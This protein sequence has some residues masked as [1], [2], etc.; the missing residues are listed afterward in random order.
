MFPADQYQGG[1]DD[2]VKIQI[3]EGLRKLDCEPCS[4][5]KFCGYRSYSLVERHRPLLTAV[6]HIEWLARA[7]AF[8]KLGYGLAAWELRHLV[9]FQLAE[10]LATQRRELGQGEEKPVG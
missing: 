8:V 9:T 4:L 7:S 1:M 3:D 6:E 2:C 5:R 10:A